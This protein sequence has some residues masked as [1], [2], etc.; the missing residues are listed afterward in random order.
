M[1]PKIISSCLIG[2]DEFT[3]SIWQHSEDF[4]PSEVFPYAIYFCEAH[5]LPICT[6]PFDQ[7]MIVNTATG[8][9]VVDHGENAGLEP[10]EI[11]GRPKAF[12]QEQI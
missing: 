1:L 5:D 7:F 6:L 11:Y 12:D 4:G 2:G 3:K 8:F 9:R 10:S